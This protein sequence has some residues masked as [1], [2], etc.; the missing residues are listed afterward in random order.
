MKAVRQRDTKPEL[1]LRSALHRRGLRFRVDSRP[2]AGSR[3]RADVLLTR[4]RLA[5]YVDGCFWHRCPLHGTLP[6]TNDK[7]WDEKLNA[8][9]E[10]DRATDEELASAGWLPVRIWEHEDPEKVAPRIE[11]LYLS[12][13]AD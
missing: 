1:A 11:A 9:V 2:L 5:I 4:A 10:R 7:W 12:R 13:V 8:N 3:R 6:K